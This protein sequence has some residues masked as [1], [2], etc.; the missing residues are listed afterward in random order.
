MPASLLESDAQQRLADALF[1]SSRY[2]RVELHLSK[3]LAGA[4]PDAIGWAKD[5]AMNPAVLTAFA[6]AIV[7]DGQGPAYPGIPGHE[8]S[9]D[10]G[11]QAA[12]RDRSVR[13]STSSCRG[14]DG[15]IREREQLLRERMATSV[16]GK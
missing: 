6:L 4:P 7:A 10:K 9:V 1:A 16:L 13:E 15:S 11:R 14:T 8:P 2:S 5:T 12:T 3:G